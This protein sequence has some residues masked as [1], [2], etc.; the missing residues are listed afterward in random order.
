MHYREH[1][2][3]FFL[4]IWKGTEEHQSY[5]C[6]SDHF[7]VT[8]PDYPFITCMSWGG[9]SILYS[10]LLPNYKGENRLPVIASQRLLLASY[11]RTVS[12]CSQPC[13]VCTTQHASLCRKL[14]PLSSHGS[15][16]YSGE[17]TSRETCVLLPYLS[18][19]HRNRS[20]TCAEA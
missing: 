1:K 11:Q 7:S 14:C 10:D 16:L 18:S 6:I 17:E 4:R 15:D 13:T 2:C 3:F 12:C 19:L 9:W 5:P 20:T 8:F